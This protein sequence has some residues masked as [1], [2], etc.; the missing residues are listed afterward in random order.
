VSD[1]GA[2]E[3]ATV[4]GWDGLDVHDLVRPFLAKN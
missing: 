1:G 4:E 3:V 2:E